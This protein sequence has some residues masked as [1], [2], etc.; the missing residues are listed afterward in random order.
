MAIT[1]GNDG[2][3]KTRTLKT[4]TM[5]LINKQFKAGELKE[6]YAL[7]LIEDHKTE[8]LAKLRKSLNLTHDS[9]QIRNNLNELYIKK[10]MNDYSARDIEENTIRSTKNVMDNISKIMDG[11]DLAT[12]SKGV[13]L[14]RWRDDKSFTIGYKRSMTCYLNGL[15]RM[16][17]R[18]FKVSKPK[19]IKKKLISH[20]TQNKLNRLLPQ[21]S[22]DIDRL[23]TKLFFYTGM[24]TGEL[25]ALDESDIKDGLINI[26]AQITRKGDLKLPKMGKTRTIVFTHKDLEG[27]FK[28]WFSLPKSTRLSHR[29][30]YTKRLLDATR[31]CFDDEVNHL[32]AHGLRRSFAI[33]M[34][35][36]HNLSLTKTA[37][38]LGD[39]MA[40]VQEYY[41]GYSASENILS[42]IREQIGI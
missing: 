22:S 41:S 12:S 36:D 10:Y 7:S 32:S 25:F 20:I 39:T 6:D 23:I 34:I 19:I 9:R 1:V 31:K 30:T 8:E 29:C 38:L 4:E 24:R 28:E 14:R 3:Q 37:M 40:V 42:S 26:N 18:E 21:M 27:W 35:A 13:I 2:K 5:K 33:H 11:I 16:A 17:G 15:L